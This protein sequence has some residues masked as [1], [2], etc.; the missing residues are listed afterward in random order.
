MLGFSNSSI[1]LRKQAIRP[2][3]WAFVPFALVTDMYWEITTPQGG[4]F[5]PLAWFAI[6]AYTLLFGQMIESGMFSTSILKK[7]LFG[8]DGMRPLQ[9]FK[10]SN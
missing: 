7:G 5:N 8:L 9:Y 6:W 3:V 10:W 1:G 2:L 4:L